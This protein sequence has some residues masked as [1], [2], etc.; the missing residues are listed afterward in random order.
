MSDFG[1][2]IAKEDKNVQIVPDSDLVFSSAFQ[3]LPIYAVIKKEYSLTSLSS[4]RRFVKHGLPF[5]PTYLIY[6]KGSKYSDRWQFFPPAGDNV[7][8]PSGQDIVLDRAD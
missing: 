5:I 6:Y 8:S 3:A 4:V 7:L 1:V 2:K